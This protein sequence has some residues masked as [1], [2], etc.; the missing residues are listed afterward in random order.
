MKSH[1]LCLAFIIILLGIGNIVS[2]QHYKDWTE[3]EWRPFG[4]KK[5]ELQKDY[6]I[7]LPEYFINPMKYPDPYKGL[8]DFLYNW[9][10]DSLPICDWDFV[11]IEEGGILTVKKGFRWDG[12][13]YPKITGRGHSYFNFRSS[14]IHDALYDMMRMDYLEPDTNHTILPFRIPF[15]G[16][17]YPDIH[18]WSDKGDCNR[19]M[20]DMMIYM[21]AVEDGQ[22]VDGKQSAQRDFEVIRFGGAPNTYNDEKMDAWKYHVSELTAYATDG[23]VELN[24][25]QANYSG[26]DPDFDDHFAP[27]L[28]YLVYRDGKMIKMHLPFLPPSINSYMDTN[29]VN[30]EIYRYKI[31]PF[32]I[33]KN[34]YDYTS[35]EYAVPNSGPGNALVL[36]GVNDYVEA[37][38]LSND[39][40]GR[41]DY[42]SVLTMEA[43]VYPDEQIGNTRSMILAFNKIV[44]D[45]LG[46][47]YNL[48]YYDGDSHTFCYF[49]TD[50]DFVCGSDQFPPGDWYHVALTLDE[51][52]NGCLYVNGE[53]Q[54]TF[55]ATIRPTYGARFS[56]GQEYD[57]SPSDFFRGMIDEVRIW[58][59]ARTQSEIQ[60]DMYHPLRGDESGLVGLWHFDEK[61]NFFTLGG[62]PAAMPMRKAFDATVNANDGYLSGYEFHEEPFVPSCA[63]GNEDCDDPDDPVFTDIY[64]DIK[65]G[66]CPNPLNA[67]V[68]HGNG[69]GP[70]KSV[71]PVAIL[72][73]E[74]FDIADIN[75][76]TISL[77]GV[78]PTRWDYE[79]VAT[80]SD[81]T[82][83]SCACT[84]EAADGYEDLTIKF[85]RQDVIEAIKNSVK[86]SQ[87]D[88]TGIKMYRDE[89][90]VR[91]T[92]ELNDGTSLQGYDCVLYMTKGAIEMPAQVQEGEAHINLALLGN[93]PNPFNPTTRISFALPQTAHV[94]IDIFNL[95]GRRVET[96]VDRGC[97]A[98]YHSVEWNAS[99][100]A[101]GVYL[102]RLQSGDFID[103]KKML[104][105]K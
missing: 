43:W 98:G 79:D 26:K 6:T 84:E 93:H 102:Y 52:D 36:D 33:N 13:S 94:R 100:L 60:A 57:S 19:L 25:K 62:F 8:G 104:F 73:T 47:N 40:V 2:A 31:V 4:E 91:L 34:Q 63:M 70:A 86:A 39:L 7:S 44:N 21:I 90:K 103:T 24:W 67:K 12:P 69:N 77:A 92:A 76:E 80:P 53:E 71:L 11:R 58:G 27:F 20:T 1:H 105:L 48:L 23:Q 95:L 10:K 72:G 74:D 45:V 75:P 41:A 38:N 14:M 3:Y 68:N 22:K 51:N 46:G 5:Y 97:E 55:T 28:G 32:E 16:Y 59:V 56:I 64:V 85:N 87:N 83:D 50:N 89:I 9:S 81:K 54:L 99:H 15:Y 66:S 17:V 35:E 30:G 101:S 29:V 42:D 61:S 82:E 65:P 96:L 49:D 37:N 18:S 78:S 88:S